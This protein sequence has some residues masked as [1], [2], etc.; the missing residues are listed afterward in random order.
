M[1]HEIIPVNKPGGRNGIGDLVGEILSELAEFAQIVDGKPEKGKTLPQHFADAA[2]AAALLR[3]S[4]GK[5][6]VIVDS[7]RRK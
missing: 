5:I 4:L 1:K 3:S 7:V 6:C 2:R